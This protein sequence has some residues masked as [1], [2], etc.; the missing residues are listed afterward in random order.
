[1]L[2]LILLD[3]FVEKLERKGALLCM[4]LRLI[5]FLVVW[6]GGF[7]NVFCMFR[8][9]F[10]LW[11]GK[12]IMDAK[13]GVGGA[14]FFQSAVFSLPLSRM[15]CVLFVFVFCFVLGKTFI[16]LTKSNFSIIRLTK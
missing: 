11:G 15:L 9:C 7:E 4:R 10:V 16:R 14:V 8:K 3:S 2:C 6:G 5:L 12:G 1:M 13:G